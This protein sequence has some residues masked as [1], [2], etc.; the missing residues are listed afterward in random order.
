ML[1]LLFDWHY[2]FFDA[3]CC[4]L[5]VCNSYHDGKPSLSASASGCLLKLAPV[6]PIL[7]AMCPVA[8]HTG[9][10]RDYKLFKLTG[11]LVLQFPDPGRP[12]IRR[13]EEPQPKLYRILKESRKFG[14]QLGV[15]HVGHLNDACIDGA[16]REV[17]KVAEG[18]HEKRI[19]KTLREI[20]G[21][22]DDDP[23]EPARMRQ[24][25]VRR[26]KGPMTQIY[27]DVA[28][29]EGITARAAR[30][31]HDE[32]KNLFSPSDDV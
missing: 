6:Y 30:R 27:R 25:P 28:A 31:Y 19:A 2:F 17:I 5:W 11:D 24:V 1:S 10:F 7:D 4:D 14:C 12:D 9:Y 3:S 32:F 20:Q 18:R 22:P 23:T 21:I 13:N 16:I 29:E 15:G 8:P 26:I